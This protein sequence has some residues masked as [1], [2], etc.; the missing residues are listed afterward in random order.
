MNKIYR[1]SPILSK[2]ELFEAIRY[3]ASNITGLCKKTTGEE[4]PISSLSVF[5]HYREEFVK[6][7]KIL[8]E[9]GKLDHENNGPF[10]R[11]DKPIQLLKNE[12]RLIR[13][14]KPDPYRMQV[15]CGDFIIPD[16]EEFKNKHLKKNENNLRLIKRPEYEMIEFF[17]P[18][19]DVLAYVLSNNNKTLQKPL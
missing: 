2:D 5:A 17:D 6:L 10:V 9:L 16:Y 3:I 14:R 4:Y 1:F 12:I 19:Y 13:V 11:L 7:K 18:D 15:G 8:L